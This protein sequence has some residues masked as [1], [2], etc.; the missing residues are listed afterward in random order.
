MRLLGYSLLTLLLGVVVGYGNPPDFIKQITAVRVK[1]PI[2]IDGVLSESIYRQPGIK[3]FYQKDPN[4]GEPV[5]EPTEVW[6]AYDDEA[7]YIG[8]MLKDSHPDSIIAR[9]SRRDNNVG[10]D[11]FGVGIDS[12]HDKRNGYKFIVSASGTLIDGTLYNDDW[13]DDSWNGVWEAKPVLLPDGWSVEMRIPFSQLRFEEQEKYIW[14]IAFVREIGRK[15]EESYTVYTPRNESG[16]VSRMAELVGIEHITPPSRFE[17]TPY[18]TGRAEYLQHKSGDPFNSGSKYKPDFGADFKLGL[19]SNLTLDGAVNPDFGQVEVD[20]A[21]VNLG[22][23]ETYY[24]EKR[25]FFLEG[26]NI[27]SFGQGGVSN[28]WSF[29]WSNPSLFYSRR[30][31]RA[32]ERGLPENDY[33]DVPLGTRILGAAKL[34]GKAFNGWNVGIIEAVTNREYAQVVTSG[35]QRDWEVEPLSSYTVARVQRD[36]NDGKQGIGLLATSV[37]RFFKDDG[38]RSAVNSDAFIGGFDGWTAFDSGKVYMISGWTVFSRVAGTKERILD[39]QQGWPHYFERPD[40]SH[41]SIDSSATSMSGFAG[42]YTLNKQKGRWMLNAALGFVSPGFESGD[43]GYLSR[44]DAINYHVGTGYKWNDPTPYYRDIEVLGSYFASSDFGGNLTWRGLW[45]KI[46]YQFPN[47]H[48]FEWYYD[49]GFESVDNRRTRGGPLMLNLPAYEYGVNYYTDNRNDYIEEAYWYAYEGFDGFYHNLSLYLT[50]RPSSN[51]SITIG[52]GYTLHSNKAQWVDVFSDSY[53]TATYGKR[54]IFADLHYKEL[55]AQIRVNWTLSP[56]LSFQMFVQPLFASGD[57]TNFK[58]LAR[59]RSFDFNVFGQNGSLFAD[60]SF[61]D[62]SRKIYLSAA[63]SP[64]TMSLDHPNFNRVSLRGNAVLRWEYMPGS[65]L[66]FV[67]TQSRYD[68]MLDGGFN[69]RN[70]FDRLGS[71]IAD[72]IFMIK[73]TYWLGS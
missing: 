59:P 40:A 38:V 24:D 15:K 36:F 16:F 9:L 37:H 43:L 33:A 2:K 62:G 31:G 70:S 7:L 4:Q 55:S 71:S 69:M 8:A 72:N 57:Y 22:D 73:L 13:S 27:F 47:Y 67:W 54:Y 3:E 49:Y 23:A 46:Y 28:Y 19:G 50:M 1:E 21:V 29:N 35:I 66:F 52:P 41:L 61:S 56:T 48:S 26:M 58:E 32:P 53:A 63:G 18:M 60:S 11:R 51:V 12:Y 20:P 68:N 34:T 65:T 30:I 5:S 25:P 45:G 6:V 14:G 17:A 44:T 64:L 10:G 42:R 39:L